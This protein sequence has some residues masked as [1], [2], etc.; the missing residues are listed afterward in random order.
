MRT[1]FFVL[2][3]LA[4]VA[5]LY[6]G[7]ANTDSNDPEPG[8]ALESPALHRVAVIVALFLCFYAVIVVLYLAA[9]GRPFT[10][11][12]LPG[13]TGVA[14]PETLEEETE[15]LD[16]LSAA[17]KSLAAAIADHENRLRTLEGLP[18]LPPDSG[19]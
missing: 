2:T 8:W 18:P 17:G 15:A 14:E 3:A 4:A 10:Q 12:R 7:L 5:A 13:G 19:A 1:A 9:Q 11:L 6:L 16:D